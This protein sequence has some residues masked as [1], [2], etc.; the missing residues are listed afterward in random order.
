MELQGAGALGGHR[1]AVPRAPPSDE[2]GM[3]HLLLT[4]D[5]ERLYRAVRSACLHTVPIPEVGI[6]NSSLRHAGSHLCG[7]YIRG[8]VCELVTPAGI[9]RRRLH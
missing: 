9:G 7:Q 1:R 8:A 5:V 6:S 2:D 3:R 4:V